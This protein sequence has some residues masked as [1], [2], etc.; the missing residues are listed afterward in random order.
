MKEIGD[1]CKY[2]CIRPFGLSGDQHCDQC[3]AVSN[4][5]FVHAGRSGGQSLTSSLVYLVIFL[6]LTLIG[7]TLGPTMIEVEDALKYS[8]IRSHGLIFYKRW[9]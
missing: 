7:A 8:R 2:C 3:E 1:E 5:N 6:L 9:N 4:V